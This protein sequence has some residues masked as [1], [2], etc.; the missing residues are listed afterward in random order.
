VFAFLSK[1]SFIT[2]SEESVQVSPRG[3]ECLADIDA[4]NK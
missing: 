2:S 3:L 1:K 4:R